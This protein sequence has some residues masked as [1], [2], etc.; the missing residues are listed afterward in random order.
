MFRGVV[1]KIVVAA[2]LLVHFLACASGGTTGPSSVGSVPDAGYLRMRVESLYAAEQSNDWQSWYSLA[3]PELKTEEGAKE[4]WEQVSRPRN[5]RVVSWRI[6]RITAL[7]H[8]ELPNGADAAAAVAMRVTVERRGG[9]IDR[10]DD[11]TDY[12]IHIEGE[13]YWTWRGWPHD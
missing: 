13:W 10:D 1:F 7:Q 6:R 12:W 9:K 11:Q 5:F 2:G 8:E 3:G 4:F